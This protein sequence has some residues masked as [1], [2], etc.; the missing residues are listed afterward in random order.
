MKLVIHPPIDEARLQKVSEAA[1][2]M[3]VV[4]CNS[5]DDARSEITDADAFYGKISPEL[6]A[7]A[8]QLRWVQSPTASLEHYLFPELIEH[9]CELSNMRGLF[10]DVI[11]DHVLGYVLCFARNLHTYLRLQD[12]ARWAPIGED[13]ETTSFTTGPSQVREVDRRHLHLADCTLGVVGVGAIGSEICRRAAAF[14]MTVLGVDPHTKQVAGAVDEVWPTERLDDL[15]A[16]SDFVVIAAP[17]TPETFK[18]FRTPQF[19]AMQSTAYLINIGRGVI[20]DLADL[21]EALQQGQIAG[22]GLDVFETEPLPLCSPL[23]ELDNVLMAGHVAGL[24]N[25]SQF[26]TFTMVADTIIQLRDGKWPAERIRNLS[27]V[28]DWRWER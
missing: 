14:G 4:N 18:L 23:L 28:T 13:D 24:D 22:A 15:L 21:T 10:S 11:A 12:Q 1:G 9:P 6:L 25:E 17:H 16:A 3:R 8:E 2:T 27:G 5:A 20:V 7:A 26:D 19:E